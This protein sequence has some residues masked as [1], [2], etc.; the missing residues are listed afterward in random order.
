MQQDYCFLNLQEPKN[1]ND[2]YSMQNPVWPLA[3]LLFCF[4]IVSS[5]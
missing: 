5:V 3:V 4:S 2:M 1:K